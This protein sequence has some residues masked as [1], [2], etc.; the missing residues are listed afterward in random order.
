MERALPPGAS[1]P[2]VCSTDLR[3][4]DAAQLMAA[5]EVFEKD[6]SAWRLQPSRINFVDPQIG[7]NSNG[8][9]WLYGPKAAEEVLAGLG[10]A[11]CFERNSCV[12]DLKKKLGHDAVWA[13][14]ALGLVPAL[15]LG[16]VFSF[17]SGVQW[18]AARIASGLSIAC[19]VGAIAVIALYAREG[20]A[21]AMML[22]LVGLI[23]VAVF[24]ATLWTTLGLV[25]G[26]RRR[27]AAA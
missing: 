25:N 22:S 13:T 20:V 10:K 15:L 23:A 26:L 6:P 17:F 16:V 21:A 2:H 18:R 19:Y 5:V 4:A 12:E 27:K 9:Y 3:N 8:V 1:A 11:S 24:N 7:L 14:A